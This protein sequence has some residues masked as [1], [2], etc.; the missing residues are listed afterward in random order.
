MSS[1]GRNGL[2]WG[3]H[4]L[5]FLPMLLP[6]HDRSSTWPERALSHREQL[7][8]QS[9]TAISVF[10]GMGDERGGLEALPKDCL[11]LC[12]PAIRIG[13]AELLAPESRSRIRQCR[14]Q[15]G[16]PEE[17]PLQAICGCI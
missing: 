15:H 9:G 16:V 4:L 10:L 11:R 2:L 13:P 14:Q 6:V 5:H 8:V 3:G 17:N 7:Q 1:D 12:N